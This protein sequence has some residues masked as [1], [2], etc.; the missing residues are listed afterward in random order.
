MRSDKKAVFVWSRYPVNCFNCVMVT[1]A[2]QDRPRRH[3]GES[4]AE[5]QILE[6]AE[7]L[8]ATKSLQELSVGDINEAAGVSRTTFYFYFSSKFAVVSALLDS[9]LDEIYQ[10]VRPWIESEGEASVEFLRSTLVT[11]THTWLRHGPLMRAV[12]ENLPSDQDLREQWYTI[13]DRFISEFAKHIDGL[14][15]GGYYPPGMDSVTLATGLAWATERVLYN[16][17]LDLDPRFTDPDEIAAF[18]F[19]LWHGT[20]AAGT[21]PKAPARRPA[22]KAATKAPA[23]TAPKAGANGTPK[24]SSRTRR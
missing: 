10:G 18:L 15:A 11:T 14:R 16:S 7:R 13:L 23:K 1:R 22:T 6:A 21:A 20:I 12:L 9:R 8:L 3:T 5:A 24:Q 4:N 19:L 2:V 17:T